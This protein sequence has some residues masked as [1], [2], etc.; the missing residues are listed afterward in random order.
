MDYLLETQIS[1]FRDTECCLYICKVERKAGNNLCRLSV[2]IQIFCICRHRHPTSF[3]RRHVRPSGTLL[4][5]VLSLLPCAATFILPRRCLVYHGLPL[6]DG[7]PL[8][9]DPS[10]TIPWLLLS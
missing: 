3:L 9:F 5:L 10:R 8:V 7:L 1:V 4:F 2:T 6:A